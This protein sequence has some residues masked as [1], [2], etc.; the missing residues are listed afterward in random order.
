MTFGERCGLLALG[1]L[2]FLVAYEGGRTLV[3]IL[4]PIG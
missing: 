2:I 3:M 4:S 1:V